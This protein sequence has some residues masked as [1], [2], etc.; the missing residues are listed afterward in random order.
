[1]NLSWSK[2]NLGIG[3]NGKGKVVEL[4]IVDIGAVAFDCLEWRD[5]NLTLRT[6]DLLEL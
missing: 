5:D 3:A 6:C 1:M 2:V 4:W